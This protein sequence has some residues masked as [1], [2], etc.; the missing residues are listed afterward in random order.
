MIKRRV[1]SLTV[2][3]DT[4]EQQVHLIFLRSGRVLSQV[5]LGGFG[6]PLPED[7]FDPIISLAIERAE[8]IAD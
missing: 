1:T 2:Q 4:L 7:L 5:Q 6:E 3:G 8:S